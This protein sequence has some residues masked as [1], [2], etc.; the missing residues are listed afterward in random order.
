M[1]DLHT[2]PGDDEFPWLI[3]V[4]VVVV[5]VVIV[6]VVVV[7]VVVLC[8]KKRRQSNTGMADEFCFVVDW[9]LYR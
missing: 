8:V 7:V 5:V 6:I 9:R 4:I 2:E 1:F 3:I